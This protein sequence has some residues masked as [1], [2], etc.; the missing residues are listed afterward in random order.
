MSRIDELDSAI[1]NEA[2]TAVRDA[3][4]IDDLQAKFEAAGFKPQTARK[5]AFAKQNREKRKREAI[6]RRKLEARRSSGFRLSVGVED[7]FR[8]FNV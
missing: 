8:K 5:K 7:A 2:D 3:R 4:E 1:A 6:T